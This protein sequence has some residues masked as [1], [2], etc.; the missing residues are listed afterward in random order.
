MSD[1]LWRQAVR[2]RL[3]PEAIIEAF[4][5]AYVEV[6]DRAPRRPAVLL[7]AAQSLHETAGGA[8]IYNYN[9][10]G[11]KAEAGYPYC[12]LGTHELLPT[13]QA[14]ALLAAGKALPPKFPHAPRPGRKAVYLPASSGLEATKFR[15]FERAEEGAWWSCRKYAKGAR[16]GVESVWVAIETGDP[17][18]FSHAIGDLGYYSASKSEYAGAMVKRL[19]EASA[20]AVDWDALPT[21]SARRAKELIEQGALGLWGSVRASQQSTLA[22]IERARRERDGEGSEGDG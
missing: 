16:Y 15:A 14:D 5:L 20:V 2:T 17:V 19:A 13:A 4:A 7:L 1:P 21:V 8:N 9:F 6:F 12:H 18:A 11:L 10:S 3:E 22:D